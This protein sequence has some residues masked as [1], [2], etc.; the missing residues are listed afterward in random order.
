MAMFDASSKGVQFLGLR[1]RVARFARDEEG[2]LIIL[3]LQIFLIMMIT[4][5]IAIDIVR[6]E[7]RRT[8]IQATLDRAMLAAADGSPYPDAMA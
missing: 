6:Q 5:G 8:L 7:E 3:S 4:T 2:S 1:D